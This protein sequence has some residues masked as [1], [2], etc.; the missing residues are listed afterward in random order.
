M[1]DVE[2]RSTAVVAAL[3]NRRSQGHEPP[4]Q[5]KDFLE[6][7]QRSNKNTP[8]SR[9]LPKGDG[10]YEAQECEW[11]ISLLQELNRRMESA[12]TWRAIRLWLMLGNFVGDGFVAHREVGLQQDFAAL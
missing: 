8:L 6:E 7:E 2:H 10:S 1:K 12:E 4:E 11:Q 9:L 3:E 5:I